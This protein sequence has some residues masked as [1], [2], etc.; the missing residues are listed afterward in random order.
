MA[1]FSLNDYFQFDNGKYE[2]LIQSLLNDVA[3]QSSDVASDEVIE[4]RRQYFSVAI[5]KGTDFSSLPDNL[6][7]LNKDELAE[8]AKKLPDK[9]G[10]AW[11]LP[12]PV[13][14]SEDNRSN[15][16]FIASQRTPE[17]QW[18]N[19]FPEGTDDIIIPF[20]GT[21]QSVDD[22]I[23]DYIENHNNNA[24]AK[25]EEAR[26]QDIVNQQNNP[27]VRPRAGRDIEQRS[28]RRNPD[29]PSQLQ[30]LNPNKDGNVWETGPK[31]GKFLQE[32]YEWELF[33]IFQQE[34][35]KP[36][37]SS[38]NDGASQFND[39]SLK[40]IANREQ[41]LSDSLLEADKL[42]I[43]ISR[44]PH[45]VGEMSTGQR[46]RSCMNVADGVNK[47][48]VPEDIKAGSLVAYVVHEDD[49]DARYPLMR[50][51]IKPFKN[52][53]GET[54]LVPQK[55]YGGEGFDNARTR[56]ALTQ[57][58]Q[59]FS[60]K[61]NQ[62]KSG[63]FE[64]LP[65]LYKDGQATTVQLQSDWSLEN[66]SEAIQQYQN[67]SLQEVL[68]ELKSNNERLA[69][70]EKG[71]HGEDPAISIKKNKSDIN[72]LLDN[73]NK[74]T[75]LSRM[76]FRST[77]KA[78]IG[79][80][81]EPQDICNVA[82][83]NNVLSAK[84][85][86][87]Q[88]LIKGDQSKWQNAIQDLSVE[89]QLQITTAVIAL[90]NPESEAYQLA[91]D[92]MIKS[93]SNEESP[94]FRLNS[95]SK[96]FVQVVGQQEFHKKLGNAVLSC[97]DDF[98]TPLQK[99]HNLDIAY[100]IF[101][102]ATIQDRIVL[103]QIKNHSQKYDTAEK[104]VEKAFSILIDAGRNNDY[105]LREKA[106]NVVM[107]ETPNLPTAE[108]RCDK[109]TAIHA[110]T[111]QGDFATSVGNKAAEMVLDDVRNIKSPEERINNADYIMKHSDN[112]LGLK[113][114]AAEIILDNIPKLSDI[115][116]RIDCARS[117]AEHSEENRPAK[118]KAVELM[119]SNISKLDT[120]Q[121]R[122]DAAKEIGSDDPMIKKQAAKVIL[123]EISG[124]DDGRHMKALNTSV[125][126]S[127]VVDDVKYQEKALKIIA[128]NKPLALFDK[129]ARQA[130][131]D[132]TRH[133][134]SVVQ[135]NVANLF[136]NNSGSICNNSDFGNGALRKVNEFK[137][138]SV[139]ITNFPKLAEV[140]KIVQKD[141][142]K[143][144]I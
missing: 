107:E 11:S 34:N 87:F 2:E 128:R 76:F 1:S 109:L 37:E 131:V 27:E 123:D 108:M 12:E 38:K 138:S 125:A 20:T 102:N 93:A 141:D 59:S 33:D 100:E 89:A 57:T 28:I 54:I 7:G 71:V 78:S 9:E 30:T 82:E 63:K 137:D 114:R 119:F 55:I 126:L 45:K 35:D 58:T 144:D 73:K 118:N 77:L 136:K 70:G 133:K 132:V 67:G 98:N 66:I 10:A 121:E 84:S 143:R 115:K 105:D 24:I 127:S 83:K 111:W 5:R 94:A 95:Y 79:S 41:N 44:D 40:R 43:L 68:A 17:A 49:V 124:T 97:I 51:L 4:A 129:E 61:Q 64:M 74:E 15:F 91:S 14:I 62:G 3:E 117:V 25:L 21:A 26:K 86:A 120:A 36:R 19:I 39:T 52:E 130:I 81:P 135:N 113:E 142:N 116:K 103:S 13:S 90:N 122:Y 46:W 29:N 75:G 85:N 134:V 22:K 104:C 8:A 112:N 99:L 6:S 42:R 101:N 18:N 48:Y 53:A 47:H 139:G 16:E 110:R 23:G 72:R 32:R 65:E 88:A 31:L 96:I 92:E 140:I 69:K 80:V 50:Q 56:D 60:A 106:M